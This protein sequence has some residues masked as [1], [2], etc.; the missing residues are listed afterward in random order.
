MGEISRRRARQGIGSLGRFLRDCAGLRC[1]VVE[2]IIYTLSCSSPVS[3]PRYTFFL[4]SAFAFP[5]PCVAME[6]R[7][8]NHHSRPIAT[9]HSCKHSP[10][11]PLA[12]LE[13]VA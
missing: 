6:S 4:I 3:P 11:R 13:R 9:H 10:H 2:S 8:W 1:E 12:V 5:F 7:L